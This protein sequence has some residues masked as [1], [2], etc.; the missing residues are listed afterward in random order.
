MVVCGLSLYQ[1]SMESP[2]TLE[3]KFIF[4]F[5]FPFLFIPLYIYYEVTNIQQLTTNA[6]YI[7][8]YPPPHPRGVCLHF[9]LQW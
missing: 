8:V 9:V 1:E 3:Q 7:H 6:L 4:S 2:K 5:F